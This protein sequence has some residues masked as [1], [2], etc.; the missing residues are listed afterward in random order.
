MAEEVGV[1]LSL[2]G[3]REFTAGM[4]DAGDSV[5][6]FG[7]KAGD[8]GRGV[9]DF[10]DKAEVAQGKAKGL[11]SIL[12]G[13]AKVVGGIAVKGFALGAAGAT[14]LGGALVATGTG[15][16]ALEQSSRAAFSTLLGSRKEANAFM[17][18][19]HE[20]GSSSPFPRQA[21]IAGA[22]QLVGF[23]EEAENIV[24]IFGAIQDA[25]AATG[26]GAEELT[27]II[28]VFADI[29][30]QGKLTGDSIQRL[31]IR[32]IDAVGMIAEATGETG[33]AI[34]KDIS[35]G[36]IGADEAISILIAGMDE[37][38]GGAAANVKETWAGTTDSV[39]AAF[40]DIGSAIAEPFISKEGGGLAIEWGNK[41]SDKLWEIEDQI[42]AIVEAAPDIGE[43]FMA[44]DMASLSDIFDDLFPPGFA[45][46]L[47]NISSVLDDLGTVLTDIVI[48]TF[49]DFSGVASVLI[50]PLGQLDDLL[51]WVADNAETLQ[52]FVTDL[53][54]A[55]LAWKTAVSLA[56][57]VLAIQTLLVA[58]HNG[59]L[60]K[61]IAQSVIVRGAVALWTGAQWLLNAA[62]TANPIG[63]VVAA[64][65]LLVAGL[66]L[67]YQK[68][69]TFRDMV[70]TAWEA[71]KDATAQLV[72]YSI[73]ALQGLMNFFLTVAENMLG[74]AA[75]LA[76][77]LG[78]EGLAE[79]LEVAKGAIGVFRDDTNAKLDAIQTEMQIQ[80]D[81]SP[82]DR[83]LSELVKSFEA[84]G[85]S[86]NPRADAA[87]STRLQAQADAF[88]GGDGPGRPPRGPS[89]PALKR[90]QSAL[91]PGTTITST[92]RTPARNRAVGGSPTSYHMDRSNPAVDIGGSTAALNR[93][94]P[95]LRA[96]GGWREFLWRVPG[97]YDHIHVAHAGGVVSRE[98][99]TI[100]GLRSDE[101]PAI[102]QVGETI[103]P[104]TAAVPEEVH[105][106]PADRGSNGPTIIQV[107]LDRRV[108]A[109]AVY[110]DIRDKAAR[111]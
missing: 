111:R 93:L 52:P 90:V 63:L 75:S 24:P 44:G 103:V 9:A 34:R 60:K 15:Y 48:P 6:D 56:N 80:I 46:V 5:D 74:T 85:F 108:L 30:G 57:V 32:G 82:A 91:I 96:M 77:G 61:M 51:G 54:I 55:F 83:A 105:L 81:T 66:V 97:H 12:G 88:V 10:G 13:V 27:D 106:P 99:A 36:A 14:T 104:R 29:R 21:F 43:A 78:M 100:P 72:I 58:A 11:G 41:L 40:R 68:S 8:A 84:Q 31:G 19:L 1:R 89:G 23:G 59:G 67:A 3:K 94:A 95:K 33:E 39:K 35:E 102:V 17:D 76:R 86:Q 101:R 38:F 20:F 22:Q 65:A 28:N 87:W 4:D 49:E 70:Q 62:L 53:A 73:T 109:E 25:V 50:S 92:Y 16:N 2:K 45:D 71:I 110:D 107:T 42:P 64:I 98:W 37:K 47:T 18:E 26:G 69:E 7:R 79:D